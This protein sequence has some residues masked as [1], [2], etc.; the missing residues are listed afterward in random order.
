MELVLELTN[1]STSSLASV[2]LLQRTRHLIATHDRSPADL[3]AEVEE[4][5]EVRY[6]AHEGRPAWHQ[7][8]PALLIGLEEY[9][10]AQ[11]F[12][13]QLM[14]E[15]SKNSEARNLLFAIKSAVGDPTIIDQLPK[16]AKII[17][18]EILSETILKLSRKLKGQKT[19]EDLFAGLPRS[20]DKQPD[21]I[22]AKC[23]LNCSVYLS[24]SR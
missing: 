16:Y 12:A 18:E 6:A 23:V 5:R 15:S 20:L 17:D 2:F 7:H 24:Y 3:A 22:A 10:S 14:E 19:V 11:K 1:P 4:V 13:D 8:L 21:F 9:S